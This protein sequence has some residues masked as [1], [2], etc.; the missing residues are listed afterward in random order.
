MVQF[1][2][3]PFIPEG[4]LIN[5]TAEAVTLHCE[6]DCTASDDPN[7][8]TCPLTDP[9]TL[10]LIIGNEFTHAFGDAN[11]DGQVN[12]LDVVELVN[13]IISPQDYYNWDLMFIISDLNEDYF[14]NT[15]FELSDVLSDAARRFTSENSYSGLEVTAP[16]RV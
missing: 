1:D 10:S 6:E 11:F 9:V 8:L 16:S 3:S 12:V 2:V 7:C 4:T 5:F 15:S 14:L 13:H